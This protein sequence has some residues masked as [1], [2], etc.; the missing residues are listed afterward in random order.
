MEFSPRPEIPTC[1]LDGESHGSEPLRPVSDFVQIDRDAGRPL[2]SLGKWSAMASFRRPKDGQYALTVARNKPRRFA[3]PLQGNLVRHAGWVRVPGGYLAL[4]LAGRRRSAGHRPRIEIDT[5]GDQPPMTDGQRRD[6]I[7]RWAKGRK[8]A[9]TP[10]CSR[11]Q[12]II[13]G[14]DRGGTLGI[15]DG[16]R[17]SSRTGPSRRKIG[18]DA[19]C[20]RTILRPAR[21]PRMNYLGQ[22]RQGGNRSSS[23]WEIRRP[24][25]QVASCSVAG[26]SRNGASCGNWATGLSRCSAW[27]TTVMPCVGC[28]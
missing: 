16:P 8:C 23:I 3:G 18:G 4:Q 20:R 6:D 28:F 5:F 7:Q 9:K 11:T 13:C 27:S 12:G 17:T 22:I 1:G 14:G 25:W 2:T 26:G 10:N 21:R 19:P 24:R 15:Q